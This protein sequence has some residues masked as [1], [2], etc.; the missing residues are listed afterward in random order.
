M[1]SL[2]YVNDF[3]ETLNLFITASKIVGLINYCCIMESGLFYRNINLTYNLFLELIRS[4]IYLIISYHVTFNMGI[5]VL[6]IKFNI[7]KYWAI[8]IVTRISE[9]WTINYCHC[10]ISFCAKPILDNFYFGILFRSKYTL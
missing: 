1:H 3:K 6:I 8:V 7:I 2:L 10:S 5:T 4:F 9:K